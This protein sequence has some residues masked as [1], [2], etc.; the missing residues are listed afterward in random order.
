MAALDW[1]L[2]WYEADVP[3]EEKVRHAAARYG[4]KHGEVP[5]TCFV[6]DGDMEIEEMVVDDIKVFAEPVI[7]KNHLW[8]G[9]N[10]A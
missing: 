3:V 2:L 6:H 9:V 4:E 7:L 10:N 1:G 8:I 5:N